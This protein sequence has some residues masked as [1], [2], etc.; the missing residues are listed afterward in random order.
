MRA[1]AD[2][3]RGALDLLEESVHILR[4]ISFRVLLTYFIG[5]L[6]FVAGFLYFWADMS[7]G[8]FAHRHVGEAAFGVSLLYIWMKCWQSVFCNK[9][10]S[11]LM[12]HPEEKYSLARIVRLVSAQTILQ[13]YSLI[14]LPSAFLVLLPFGWT[15]AFFQNLLVKAN[16]QDLDLRNILRTS[17]QLGL[18]WPAQNHRVLFVLSLFI[19]IVFLNIGIALLFLPSLLKSLFGIE[20]IFSL[21]GFSMLNT[22]FLSIVGAFTYLCIDPLIAVLYTLRCFYGES[23]GTGAD[24]I[25][26]LKNLPK[27]S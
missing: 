23:I 5:T 3:G 26:D 8:P 20:T 18:L 4:R 9:L 27:A 10:Y 24:L 19:L 7:R 1:K 13:P 6:P 2:S 22:T 17:W 11:G 14:V 15:F 21:S 25:S 16:G 12:G